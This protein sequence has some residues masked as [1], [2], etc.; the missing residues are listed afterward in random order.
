MSTNRIQTERSKLLEQQF[1]S[2]VLEP[3]HRPSPRRDYPKNTN[4]VSAFESLCMKLEKSMDLQNQRLKSIELCLGELLAGKLDRLIETN[5][6]MKEEV[7]RA[8]GR[9]LRKQKE[10]STDKRMGTEPSEGVVSQLQKDRTPILPLSRKPSINNMSKEDEPLLPS[11]L[12]DSRNG[13]C[14]PKMGEVIQFRPVSRLPPAAGPA[15]SQPPSKES[16]LEAAQRSIGEFIS[17]LSERMYEVYS[18]KHLSLEDLKSRYCWEMVTY[19]VNTTAQMR[20][21]I[22]ELERVDGSD[23]RI[24]LL[25]VLDSSSRNALEFQIKKYPPSKHK[26]L[27]TELLKYIA[28]VNRV[29]D[30]S[31]EMLS[32]AG[33]SFVGKKADYTREIKLWVNRLI[34]ETQRVFPEFKAKIKQIFI[35]R[36]SSSIDME[37]EIEFDV[38]SKISETVEPYTEE[39]L[40]MPGLGAKSPQII[41]ILVKWI[42]EL[43]SNFMNSNKVIENKLGFKSLLGVN[44]VLPTGRKVALYEKLEQ[45][46]KKELKPY[47]LT[48]QR[49]LFTFIGDVMMMV[50][51]GTEGTEY[52]NETEVVNS[53]IAQYLDS[54]GESYTLL[55][56]SSLMKC[57]N[58]IR[59]SYQEDDL[60][61]HIDLITFNVMDLLRCK[62]VGSK[63]QVK[64][65]YDE[66]A[67][68]EYCEIIRVKNK[69]HEGTKDILI[70]FKINGSFL[71][72]EMQLSLGD[73]KDELNDHF[74]HF[75]YELQ[76]GMFPV[77]LE[78]ASQIA[79][80]DTRV[81]YFDSKHPVKF[82]PSERLNEIKLAVKYTEGS[83]RC[84]NHH[85]EMEMQFWSN[86]VPFCCVYCS[87][88]I[89]AFQYCLEF[90]NCPECHLSVCPSCI[91]ESIP[92]MSGSYISRYIDC[93]KIEAYLQKGRRFFTGFG[94]KKQIE[95]KI[96][97][98]LEV[99]PYALCFK[100]DSHGPKQ[101]L[102]KKA[103]GKLVRTFYTLSDFPRPVSFDAES[104]WNA[105]TFIKKPQRMRLDDLK[106]YKKNLIELSLWHDV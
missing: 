77:L 100:F 66:L 11:S 99:E 67:R 34:G 94:K 23:I 49:K 59:E 12:P 88:F 14:P 33:M 5:I 98:A 62:C 106:H 70:N 42:D 25:S 96:H 52:L 38:G 47:R 22:R 103:N 31:Y 26:I 3:I 17:T 32:N 92:E 4:A 104:N 84:S 6:G 101:S 10:R 69:L 37:N 56:L 44:I 29:G 7:V 51:A 40:D 35:G 63:K 91:L 90:M 65:I 39:E 43:F 24:E 20:P 1:T 9:V 8:V 79:C 46:F 41:R 18:G 48:G 53:K 64:R 75:L 76:R 105:I 95:H 30:L 19:A 2:I 27:D 97:Q 68:S 28:Q 72:G 78:A 60:E 36:E 50:Q 93:E 45:V 102:F 74:C 80:N 87:K 73:A 57:L 16:L 86:N 55:I 82:R 15:V 61:S 85:P 83:L 54:C 13:E 58:S 89:K 21:Q 81:S 71:I